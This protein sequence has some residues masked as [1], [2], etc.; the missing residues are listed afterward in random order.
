MVKRY[1]QATAVDGLSLTAGRGEGHR[2]PR[3]ER[4]GQDHHDRGSARA[5]VTLTVARV[6]V[7]GLD[8]VRGRRPA[9]APGRRDAPGGRHPARRPG[10]RVPQDAESVPCET[11]RPRAWLLDIVG[12]T[13]HARTPYK[14]LSGGQQQRL[15]PGRRRPRP[16]RAGLSRRADRRHGPAGP[17]RDLGPG[18]G[19]QGRRGSV[20]IL[21]THFMEEAETARRPRGHHRPRPHGRRRLPRR[22]HRVGGGSSGSAPSPTSTLTASSRRCRPAAPPRSRRPAAT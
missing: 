18:H 4:R 20:V 2:D 3:A 12:L 5:T 9:Q 19:A 13:A 10:R 15:F 17:A 6:R 14:R 7:L 8:P 22:A 21:T 16:P 1:G 11:T